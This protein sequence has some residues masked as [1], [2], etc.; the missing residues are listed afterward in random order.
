M[1]NHQREEWT[2]VKGYEGLYQISTNGNVKS[3]NRFLPSANSRS[4]LLMGRLLKFKSHKDGYRF[5][6]LSSNGKTKNHYI[7]RLVAAAFIPNPDNKPQVNHIN[8]RKADNRVKNLEWVT[9]EENAIH[10]YKS[11]LYFNIG[12]LKAKSQAVLDTNTD[13]CYETI[14]EAATAL[15]KNYSMIRDML[16]GRRRNITGLE[17]CDSCDN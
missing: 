14:K 16:K 8:G 10:A 12:S 1:N 7:H 2:D 17:Y 5:V 3:K 11:G 9:Q 15:G 6:A 4:R 13:T